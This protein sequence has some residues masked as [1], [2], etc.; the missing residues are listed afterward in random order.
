MSLIDYT[1][2]QLIKFLE[3]AQNHV[4][5]AEQDEA[6][7]KDKYEQIH[8]VL[9]LA[10]RTEHKT[11]AD[12]ATKVVKN[13]VEYV[14]ARTEYLIARA[15]FKEAVNQKDRVVKTMDLWQTGRADARRV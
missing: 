12:L 8:A 7:A 1:P 9:A 6:V 15:K 14:E 3:K 4:I 13:Q 2:D 11:P 10:E 5:E